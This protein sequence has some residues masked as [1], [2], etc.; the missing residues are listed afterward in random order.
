MEAGSG[1]GWGP[2]R[3]MSLLLRLLRLMASTTVWSLGSTKM[4]R[5]GSSGCKAAGILS[6]T[7]GLPARDQGRQQWWLEPAVCTHSAAGPVAGA[8]V[9]ARAGCIQ[10]QSGVGQGRQDGRGPTT[11]SL[12]ALGAPTVSLLSW[13]CPISPLAGTLPWAC[14]DRG[15]LGAGTSAAGEA[16]CR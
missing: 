10:R 12:A 4:G 6:G 16:G 13:S 3:M 2:G 5:E 15:R 8:R 14:D 1:S 7:S 9:V 11:G